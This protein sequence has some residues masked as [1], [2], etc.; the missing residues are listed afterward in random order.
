MT[1]GEGVVAGDLGVAA[2]GHGPEAG[3]VD[4]RGIAQGDAVRAVDHRRV[5]QRDGVGSRAAGI[6]AQCHGLCAGDGGTFAQGDAVDRGEVQKELDELSARVQT[7]ID[8]STFNGNDLVS[9]PASTQTVVTGVS[10]AGG[11]FGTTSIT[12]DSVNLQAIQSTLANINVNTAGSLAGALDTA[13]GAL[14]DSIDAATSLGIAE[15]SIDTQKDFLK[16][17]TD[18]LD[19]GVGGMVDAD[20]E[21]EAARSQSLQVQQ[22]LA[23]QSLSMANQQPQSLM[24]LFR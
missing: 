15:K 7:T 24:S 2:E 16:S 23:T 21:E 19:A 20:M 22:Q 9:G 13:E 5:A 3:R 11:S 4:S 1:Q 17:L 10:R 12:F 6:V 14:S 8:Q 18:T